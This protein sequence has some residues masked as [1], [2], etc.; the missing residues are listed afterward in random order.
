MSHSH[1]VP[2]GK[3]TAYRMMGAQKSFF[4]NK[5]DKTAVPKI[6]LF[7]HVMELVI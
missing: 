5:F 7:N 1:L 4:E 6:A 3:G 2:R